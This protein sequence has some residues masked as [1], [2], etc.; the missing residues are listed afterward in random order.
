MK[1]NFKKGKFYLFILIYILKIQD[2]SYLF[3]NLECME[4]LKSDL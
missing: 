2:L 4:A 1:I 3:N